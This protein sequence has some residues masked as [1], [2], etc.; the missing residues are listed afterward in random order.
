MEAIKKTSDEAA[1]VSDVNPND[2]DW[3]GFGLQSYF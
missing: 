3:F 1:D 2:F